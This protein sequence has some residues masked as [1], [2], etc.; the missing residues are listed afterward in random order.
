MPK[1]QE[2]PKDRSPYINPLTATTLRGIYAQ[3]RP[4]TR[5]LSLSHNLKTNLP[6]EIHPEVAEALHA[7]QPAISLESTVITRGMPHP[8]N[9]WA[10]K[11]FE[12][13]VRY[14]KAYPLPPDVSKLD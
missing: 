7:R 3:S 4:E 12:R 14:R 1:Q 8:V 5:Y 13:N 11:S 9:L 2:T 6:T 10:A